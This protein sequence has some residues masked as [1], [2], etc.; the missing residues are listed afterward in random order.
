MWARIAWIMAAFIAAL[1]PAA[2]AA[3]R[4]QCDLTPD[5]YV[6]VVGVV[7][8][9]ILTLADGRRL[10]LAN[11]L[12]PQAGQPLSGSVAA[13]LAAR[14]TGK[15]MALVFETRAVD[16]HGDLVAQGI[17]PDGD[18]LQKDLIVE[19][20]A[21]VHSRGDMRRCV[22]TLLEEEAKARAAKRGLWNDPYF[23]VRGAGDLANDIGTFQTVEGK[24]LDVAKVR[25][26]VYL[27]F[28]PDYRTDFTV[29]ISPADARRLA[30]EGIDPAGWSGG[31]VRV[32]GWISLLNGPEIEL[33]HP[34]QIEVLN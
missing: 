11:I 13:R 21:R 28:G 19:G 20:F 2:S 18:W 34:E 17:L 22:G 33:T 1:A 32:R 9:A 27:N 6:S 5:E 16:R 4:L 24:V 23:R 10:R 12:V 3:G 8:P 14:V 31:T 15:P 25:K 7:E 29:T 26:R 30:R